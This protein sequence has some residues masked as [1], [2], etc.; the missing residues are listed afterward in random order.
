MR[1]LN[2]T[3]RHL[4][5]LLRALTLTFHLRNLWLLEG[6][7][8]ESQDFCFFFLLIAVST[9]PR[10]VPCTY[11]Q[12]CMRNQW[13]IRQTWFLPS[14]SLGGKIDIKQ[15]PSYRCDNCHALVA[16]DHSAKKLPALDIFLIFFIYIPSKLKP[17]T[18]ERHQNSDLLWRRPRGLI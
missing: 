5:V 2:E 11:W 7:L 14:L 1:L 13:W 12:L 17:S 8:Q 9:V 6:K 16:A 10:T 18:D 15:M 3:D 4:Q